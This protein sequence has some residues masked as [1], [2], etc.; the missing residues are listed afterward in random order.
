MPPKEILQKYA[1]LLINFAL[2]SGKGIKKGEVVYLQVNEVAKPMYVVLRNTILRAGA[3][4]ISNYMPDDVLREHYELASEE[5]L[6]TFHDKYY[7]GLIDQ[8]DHSVLIIS[9]T[10]KHE[11]ESIDPKKIIFRTKALKPFIEWRAEKE[12]KGRFTWTLA[13]YGTEAMAKE[14][15]MSL[16]DYWDKI[17][18]ACYLGEKEPIVKWKEIFREIERIKYKLNALKIEKV[19]IKGEGID[20]TVGIG[21]GRRWIGGSGRNIPSF[22]I[23]ISPDW[24]LTE[25]TVEFNQPLYRYGMLI[26]GI[27]LMFNKGVVTKA[28]ASK[29]EKLLKEIIA[30]DSGSNKIGEFSLTDSRF[31]RIDKFMGET[32]FDENIGGKYG[33]IHIALGKAYKDSYP[34]KPM[35]LSKNNW[36]KLGYNESVIHTD[37]I[38]TTKRTVVANLIDGTRKVIYKDG[39]FTI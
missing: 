7:K 6:S 23:F 2:N 15:K 30:A 37:I 17:I 34:G 14:A 21:Q 27:K 8:I 1:D 12:H 31:S 26:E 10:N 18:K 32:L 5:Q 19:Y 3:T 35:L 16:E 36:Q 13:L 38:S 22:E 33:N 4:Y 29:N 28:S 20:L 24:R 11:L 25:G 39:R 9:E